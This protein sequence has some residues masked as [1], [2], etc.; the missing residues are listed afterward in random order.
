MMSSMSHQ[1]KHFSNAAIGDKTESASVIQAANSGGTNFNLV[2]NTILS[3]CVDGTHSSWITDQLR[4]KKN[5]SVYTEQTL[6]DQKLFFICLFKKREIVDAPLSQP[7]C[8]HSQHTSPEYPI[9]L[10]LRWH[11]PGYNVVCMQRRWIRKYLIYCLYLFFYHNKWMKKCNTFFFLIH[12]VCLYSIM[13]M[14]FVMCY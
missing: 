4:P 14:H 8:W 11:L 13:W 5:I 6:S 12:S 1:L 10:C 3:F 7:K 2:K 9:M